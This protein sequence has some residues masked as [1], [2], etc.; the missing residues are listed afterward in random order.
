MGTAIMIM[1]MLRSGTSAVANALDKVGVFLGKPSEMKP[2]DHTNPEGY[3]E[4]KELNDL[5]NE[6]LL[7]LD[8]GDHHLRLF[9]AQWQEVPTAKALLDRIES[10]IRKNFLNRP[11]WAYKDPVLGLIWPFYNDVLGRLQVDP[12]FVICVRNP[13]DVAASMQRRTAQ[14]LNIGLAQWLVF[15]IACLKESIGR[16]RTVIHYDRMLQDP[17][18][19]LEPLI[20][21]IPELTPGEAH[22]R[23]L[24]DAVKP[25]MNHGKASKE[26]LK[27]L[28]PIFLATYELCLA[29]ANEPNAF[30]TGELDQHIWALYNERNFW[31]SLTLDLPPF[32]ASAA[33]TGL[34]GMEQSTYF[35][36]PS[37]DWQSARF[38][39]PPMP[40]GT[41]LYITLYFL[42]T[43]VWIRK[44]VY[45]S[46][47]GE[48]PASI[49]PGRFA[50][51]TEENG[52]KRLETT[53]RWEQILVCTPML[54]GPVQLEIEL[55]L[56]SSSRVRMEVLDHVAEELHARL[57]NK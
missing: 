18:G 45:R 43:V 48:T 20:R 26:D 2:T 15:M 30:E 34:R 51:L 50:F 5:D 53:F 10:T 40:Q 39:L 28:P 22:Y 7:A 4:F 32:Y 29:A 21:R 47:Q 52:I 11:L 16:S 46:Q 56:Q 55:L 38:A 37:G 14:P 17:K 3:W 35:L 41:E 13:L 49:S 6:C 8:L 57:Y 27:A 12:H 36:V 19:A 42:P 24:L 31:Q 9:P 54:Q 23:G 1:G 44:A 33:W 25:A